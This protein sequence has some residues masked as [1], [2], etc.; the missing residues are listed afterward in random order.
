MDVTLSVWVLAL[1]LLGTMMAGATMGLLLAALLAS[2]A[3]FD[4]EGVEGL[5]HLE[6]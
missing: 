6:C 4:P 3:R 5:E 2:S 1:L